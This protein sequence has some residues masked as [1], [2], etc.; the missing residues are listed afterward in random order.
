MTLQYLRAATL[1]VGTPAGNGKDL[2]ALRFRFIVRHADI[3][4]PNSAEIRVFNL[5]NTTVSAIQKEFTQVIIQAGYSGGKAAPGSNPKSSVTAP[6]ASGTGNAAIIFKGQVKATR[7]GRDLNRDGFTETYIDIYAGDGDQAYNYS[8]LN[9]SF[10]AGHTPLDVFNAAVQTMAP[11]GIS[12]TGGP[13][14]AFLGTVQFPRGRACFGATRDYLRTIAQTYGS[15]WTIQDGQLVMVQNTAVLPGQAIAVNA[16][17]GM[18][19][20]PQQTEEGI[21]IRMLLNPAVKTNRVLK[22]N[23]KDIAQIPFNLNSTALNNYYSKDAKGNITN[24]GLDAD[25]QYKVL[26]VDHRGDTRGQEWYTEAVCQG[27]NAMASLSKSVLGAG[28]QF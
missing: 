17:T 27:V 23:N 5:A 18:I 15:S 19:G 10:A 4:T 13:T 20:Q 2:S 25:G 7:T 11:Y 8:V 3:Q 16:A 6:S 21:T 24:L 14:P 9:Q 26:F 1:F 22:L 12:V 28:A